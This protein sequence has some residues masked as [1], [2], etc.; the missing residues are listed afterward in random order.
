MDASDIVAIAAL[1]L[2]LLVAA[3]TAVW[4]VA[5]MRLAMGEQAATVIAKMDSLR[6]AFTE[7]KEESRAQRHDHEDRIR[8][9]EGEMQDCPA[10]KAFIREKMT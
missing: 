7:F 8:R 10:L 6:S 5:S 1:V 2:A 3:G 9:L 4:A